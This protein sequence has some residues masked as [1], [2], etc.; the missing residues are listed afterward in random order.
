MKKH[1]P[2]PLEEIRAAQKRISDTIVRTPLVKLNVDDAPAEIYLKLEVLQPVGSFK[3]RGAC[4][5]MKKA[6]PADLADGVWTISGGNH[7]QGV[8]YTARQLGLDCTVVVPDFV[9]KTKVAAMKRMGS[10][11]KVVPFSFAGDIKPAWMRFLDP[12]TYGDMKG[13]FVHPFSDPDV[14]AG[15][16]TIGLEIIEDMPDVDTVVI[17]YG[18]GGL[19]CGVASAIRA[20]NPGVKL[21]GCQPETGAALA[22]S[23]SAGR[24]VDVEYTQSFVES[25]GSP[26]LYPEMWDL[27]KRLLDGGIVASI[28]DTVSAVRLL[29]ERNRVIAEGAGALSVAAALAGAAGSGKVVCVVSGASIDLEKLAKIFQGKSLE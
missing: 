5:A 8:A 29:A 26:Y 18:G 6:E 21:L 17:P 13:Y 7:G 2:I 22:A 9:A 14:M 1:D 10:E 4:N 25:A 27:A 3:I 23:F 24:P 28:E 19:C 16:G 15:Q 11:V 20:L 12:D